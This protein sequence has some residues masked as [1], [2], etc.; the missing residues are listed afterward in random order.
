[1]LQCIS[2]RSCRITCCTLARGAAREGLSQD[3]PCSELK[4]KIP[5]RSIDMTWDLIARVA[6]PPNKKKN[7]KVKLYGNDV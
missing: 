5:G 7:N 6:V 3:G 1:M 2:F 4:K